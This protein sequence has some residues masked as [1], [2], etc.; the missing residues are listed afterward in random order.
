VRWLLSATNPLELSSLNGTNGTALEGS[1]AFAASGDSVGDAGDVN[2][3]G[4]DDFVIGT[5]FASPNGT[6]RGGVSYVVF[7]QAGAFPATWEPSTLDGTNGF[8]I[9]GTDQSGSGWAVD[10]AGDVNGDG[11]GDLLIGSENG[12][13]VVFGHAG[14]FTATFEL[15]SLD[16]TNG[17]KMTSH[18][19]NAAFGRS[20]ASAGDVNGDGFDDV[21]IGAEQSNPHGN[22]SGTSYVF[23]G[24]SGA[25]APTIDVSSLDGTNGFALQGF[26]T[27]SQS[28]HALSAGDFNG[29]GFDDLLIGAN[30]PNLGGHYEGASYVVF[31]HTGSF[32][33]V[34]A[35]SSLN[36]NNGFS[37]VGAGSYDDSGSWVSN[38]GDVNGDGI[39]DVLIGA[40]RASTQGPGFDTGAAYVVF[41]HIGPFA[42]SLGLAGLDGSN[43]FRIAGAGR[44]DEAGISV[45]GAGD[46]NGDGFDDVVIGAFF[47]DPNGTSS[48][49]SYVVFGHAGPF[50]ANLNASAL[51]GT[52][53]FAINGEAAGDWLGR[54]VSGAG[55]VN[56]D[57]F[58]DIALGAPYAAPNGTKSGKSYL[59]F[60]GDFVGAVTH[61]GDGADNILNGDANA[62]D[63]VGGRGADTLIGNGGADVLRGAEGDDVLAV[64][65]TNFQRVVGGR[66]DDTLRLDGSGLTLDLT[67]LPDARLEGIETIDLT[68][69]GPNTLVLNLHEVLNISDDSNTL[70]VRG[71]ADD[72][73][74]TGPGWTTLGGENI[75]GVHFDVLTQGAATLK[76][77]QDFNIAP[78]AYDDTATASQNRQL[79]VPAPG[80]LANDFDPDGD[81][82]AA[83]AVTLP[84]HG[85]LDLHAD[86]S[87]TYLPAANYIGTD[88]FTY[89]VSDGSLTS[90]VATVRLTVSAIS[91]Q[92]GTL[93]VTGAG[94]D[95]IA[96]SA[97]NGNVVVTINGVVNTALGTIP[98]SSVQAM[99]VV[100]GTGNSLLDATGVTAAD[101]TALA[102]VLLDGHRGNDT[103]LGSPLDDSLS[104]SDDA[105]VLFGGDGNDHLDGGGSNDWID[106]GA[107][108]DWLSGQEAQDTLF[109]GPGNDY[110]QG[111][112]GNDSMDGGDGNDFLDGEADQDSML[113][114]A[115][116]D[117]L[118]AGGGND[119]VAGG[120]GNDS[121][122]ASDGDDV[123][124]GNV[125]DDTLKGEKGNDRLVG[126]AGQDSL[127]GGD[128]NDSLNG[129]AG[130]DTLWGGNNDDIL[131]DDSRQQNVLNG[132]QGQDRYDE[133]GP[134]LDLTT[135]P[136]GLWQRLEAIH[137]R[138][139][140]AHSLTLDAASV[141]NLSDE[142]DTLVVT[143]QYADVAA[144]GP[145]WTQGAP[146]FVGRGTK[147]NVFTQGS[148]T[149]KISDVIDLPPTANPDTATAV[150][151]NPL[152][153]AAPG[154][155]ANDADPNGDALQAV[156]VT[157]PQH[158]QVDLHP[159]GS[160]IYTPATDYVGT[161]SF[162]YAATD[163]ELQT[164]ATVQLTVAADAA[165]TYANGVLTIT[166]AGNSAVAIGAVGGNVI[167][168]IDGVPLANFGVVPAN[169][170]TALVV[171]ATTGNNRVDLTDVAA[172]D[173]TALIGVRVECG[174]GN[175]TLVGSQFGETLNG[176]G[177][178]DSLA[179][180]AGNDL[181]N[182]DAGHDTLDGDIGDDTLTGGDGNDSLAGSDG[183]DFL[184][185]NAGRDTLAG[186]DGADRLLAGGGS[187][188]LAG[189]AGDDTLNGQGGDDTLLGEAGADLLK[190]GAGTDASD[191]DALDRLFSIEGTYP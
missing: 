80:V 155:L 133:L 43:G 141:A 152:P 13:F 21:L 140:V 134:V 145:G 40:F 127:D 130:T 92:D 156:L 3:D 90:N 29:D 176:G 105:D 93:R 126:G 8:I 137:L 9:N 102:G 84:H 119:T 181:L 34:I 1:E 63:M 39:D 32:A 182:G 115:G 41:G 4:C 138:P 37:I 177:G 16:G 30:G 165:V 27:Y 148:A 59:I 116:N 104:G 143:G 120:D 56:G 107:G 97:E 118:R 55:D 113:G 121:L 22:Y 124:N 135:L 25:F 191:T 178:D 35:L 28:G 54:S 157:S 44:D 50:A 18:E 17:F 142:S 100:G 71:G 19:F 150:K 95:A 117:T 10:A 67:T 175:D 169:S 101:Y 161:D 42:S 151:N 77:Q 180:G 79:S 164:T 2:G 112:S 12:A 38:A 70:V 190:G 128:G 154:V 173:F 160:Y 33:P 129:N 46:V 82:L 188:R 48:G 6:F 89:Q 106:A 31:G 62:N 158:G 186:G 136:S 99:I 24:H 153:V 64:S 60:G 108:D 171:N 75:G 111:S 88:S 76:V 168:T 15:S 149:L 167:I 45:S 189:G 69:A 73:L 185:G 159:D 36:G 14:P 11:F 109:G 47:A 103:L 53:G 57:G 146:E 172:V 184:N 86:G 110:V 91:F 122:E 147:L 144:I 174:D 72:V 7:G 74:L 20:A 96:I 94:N 87:F 125:G 83:S 85:Q 131:T 187:D 66:G 170:V 163:G 52:N 5:P 58:D 179:G 23:F 162:T 26:G 123:L 132:N 81:A 61:P 114:G 139:G 98:A 78:T 68:G 166:S 49:A 65:D 51:D 183:N